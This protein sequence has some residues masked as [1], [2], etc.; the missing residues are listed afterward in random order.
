MG[1]LTE[2]EI[3]TLVSIERATACLSV[4]GTLL[5]FLTF[6]TDK[7]FRTLSNTLI[8]YASFANIMANVACLIGYFGILEG[9]DSPLCQF[10]AF[11]L[12]MHVP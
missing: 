11:L 3:G 6:I 2:Q 1:Q 5:I 4:A 10:Q 9:P 7:S 12:E 8:F